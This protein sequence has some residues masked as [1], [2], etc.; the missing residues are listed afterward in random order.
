MEYLI[1]NIRE[2]QVSQKMVKNDIKNTRAGQEKMEAI[3]EKMKANQEKTEAM[4]KPS[5]EQMRTEIKASQE[6]MKGG[7][8]EM[9]ATARA[10]EEKMEAMI[11][12][13]WFKIGETIKNLVE[14]ILSSVNQQTQG[15][16]E[17]HNKK[18]E[19]T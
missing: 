12:A 10:S 8:E 13:I 9:K 2:I 6:A 3:Q 16:R 15:L 17:E 4:I 19:E 7:L 5:L 11:N 18:I 1:A 14:D